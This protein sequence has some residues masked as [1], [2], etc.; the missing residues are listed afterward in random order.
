MQRSKIFMVIL[1]W[2]SSLVIIAKVSFHVASV[3]AKKHYDPFT[4]EDIIKY[5]SNWQFTL[6][7]HY[8]DGGSWDL[9]FLD[10]NGYFIYVRIDHSLSAKHEYRKFYLSKSLTHKRDFLEIMR[11]SALESDII[12]L[13]E[14][15][16]DLNTDDCRVLPDK[17]AVIDLLKS[18][19]L[20]TIIENPRM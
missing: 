17:N 8:L 9:G 16:R 7:N 5:G 15:S 3:E 14:S 12:K 11:G 20:E 19:D 18:R 6:A 4:V 13:I 10:S 1:S 2:L